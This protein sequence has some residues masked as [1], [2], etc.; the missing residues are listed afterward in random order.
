MSVIMMVGQFQWAR[1]VAKNCVWLNGWNVARVMPAA[2]DGMPSVR[3]K[4]K[5]KETGWASVFAIVEQLQKLYYTSAQQSMVACDLNE[6]LEEIT[7]GLN[8]RFEP[9][10][11]TEQIPPAKAQWNA[12]TVKA[13]IELAGKMHDEEKFRKERAER[14]KK[15]S[16]K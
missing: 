3:A 9:T 10:D 4:N 7:G 6:V 2:G 1:Y 12:S 15:Q 13:W 14:L 11:A 5:L 8:A 16:D